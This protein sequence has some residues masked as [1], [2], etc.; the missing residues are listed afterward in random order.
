MDDDTSAGRHVD[1]CTSV[2]TDTSKEAYTIIVYARF[3]KNGKTRGCST[4]DVAP[5]RRFTTNVCFG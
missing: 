2:D 4:V 3:A 5:M 1:M